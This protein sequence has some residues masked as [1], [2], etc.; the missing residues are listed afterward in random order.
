MREEGTY[1]DTTYLKNIYSGGRDKFIK[2]I[3]PFLYR[4][5]YDQERGRGGVGYISKGLY[6][7]DKLSQE[8]WG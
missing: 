4:L 3:L 1:R 8:D 2:V 7:M 5:C 6:G